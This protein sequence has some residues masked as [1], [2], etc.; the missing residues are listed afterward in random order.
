MPAVYTPDN[1][2]FKPP[3]NSFNSTAQLN[4]NDPLERKRWVKQQ[5]VIAANSRA[6]LFRGYVG[7]SAQ[8]II[9]RS[10]MTAS[11]AMQSVIFDFDGFLSNPPIVGKQR[12]VGKGEAQKHF[13]DQLHLNFY[14]FVRD[15]GWRVEASAYDK[16]NNTKHTYAM[17]QLANLNTRFYSQ[18]LSDAFQGVLKGCEPTHIVR[19]NNKAKTADLTATDKPTLSFLNKLEEVAQMGWGFSEGVSETRLP[20]IPGTASG[21][22]TLLVD[23]LF[24]I[25]LREDP[26]FRELIQ[27]ADVRGNNNRLLRGYIGTIGNLDIVTVP[28]AHGFMVSREFGGS[29]V[30]LPGFRFLNKNGAVTG[31]KNF[32]IKDELIGRGVIIGQSALRLASGPAPEYVYEEY[33]AKEFSESILRAFMNVAPVRYREHNGDYSTNITGYNFGM[34]HFEYYIGKRA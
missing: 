19:P 32:S 21:R 2:S 10:S 12:A 15:N 13:S 25:L 31:E 33:D 29:G 5:L 8:S 20:L 16:V 4:L 22:Y 9:Y 6:N 27:Y 7:G 23:Q 11:N 24:P 34:I 3:V 18:T 30:M 28:M 14:R 17:S 26:A 1:G